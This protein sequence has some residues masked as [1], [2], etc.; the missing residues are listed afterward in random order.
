MPR[1]QA[2]H[3]PRPTETTADGTPPRGTAGAT[4]PLPTED[5]KQKTAQDDPE[6]WRV[7]LEATLARRK[8]QERRFRLSESI[9]WLVVPLLVAWRFW[10]AFLFSST[11]GSVG[12]EPFVDRLLTAIANTE[13]SILAAILVLIAPRLYRLVFG[14]LPLEHMRQTREK[15]IRRR[16]N[17]DRDTERQSTLRDSDL[18]PEPDSEGDQFTTQSEPNEFLAALV[19]SSRILS[20][21]IFT[22]A[23]IYLS[24]GVLIAFGGVFFFYL[25]TFDQQSRAV[26][27]VF[28]EALRNAPRFGI[29]FF[30]E[31]IAIFFLRQYRSDMEEFRY[32]EAIQRKRENAFFL[33]RAMQEHDGKIDIDRLV[34]IINHS[35]GV[36]KLAPGETTELIEAK[37][38]SKDEADVLVKLIGAVT[39]SKKG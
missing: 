31:F 16:R 24:V 5:P 28:A 13:L 17:A 7:R 14:L 33:V 34:Q 22:R 9:M 29:L 15:S 36:G 3:T 25:Q 4:T 39:Q 12:L 32:Y 23:G 35:F 2:P 21:R 20:Q 37:K 10:M 8:Q 11:P 30:V 19:R 26:E 27:D 1:A 18:E 6:P 38:L